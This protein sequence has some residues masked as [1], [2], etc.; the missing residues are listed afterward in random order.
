MCV[1]VTDIIT[2][3]AFVNHLHRDT[4]D[5][6]S[7]GQSGQSE[8][9]KSSMFHLSLSVP[10]FGTHRSPAEHNDAQESTIARGNRLVS[11][12]CI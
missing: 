3:G 11:T 9:G 12:G 1:C 6:R 10:G 2:V 7:D 5:G 8:K 4:L